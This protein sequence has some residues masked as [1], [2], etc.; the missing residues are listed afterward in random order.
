MAES[1]AEQLSQFTP[2]GSGLDRDAL[3][4]A[5]GLASARPNRGWATLAC[6]LATSQLLTLVLFWPKA[7][8]LPNIVQDAP[9]AP[10]ARE[11][12]QPASGSEETELRALSNRAFVWE[13]GIP[14]LAAPV[15]SLAPESPPLRAFNGS[16]FS[17]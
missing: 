9:P 14:P 8:T 1:F 3:L 6:T 5:A 15:Q 12:F 10:S 13:D 2:D 17:N 11:D 4:F 16:Y 7:P